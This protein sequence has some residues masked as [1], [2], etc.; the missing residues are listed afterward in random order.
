MCKKIYLS[1]VFSIAITSL[2][3]QSLIE[4]PYSRFGIGDL[5]SNTSIRASGMGGT[6]IA[7]PS[8]GYINYYNPANIAYVDSLSFIFDFGLNAT[9]KR[10]SIENPETNITRSDIQI[11]HLL[12]GFRITN[13]WSAAFGAMP[14]SNVEYDIATYDSLKFDVNKYHRFAGNGG[15]NRIFLA[16]AITP[17]ENLNIGIKAAYLFGN[18]YRNSGINFDDDSGAYINTLQRNSVSISDFMLDFGVQYSFNISENNV[19]YLGATYNHNCKLSGTKSTMIFNSLSTGGSAIID[20]IYN[21]PDMTG[22]I[23]IPQKIGFGIG[24]KFS[25]KLLLGVDYSTQKWSEAD[26]FGKKDSLNN[27]N[28]FS[29]GLE[30]LPI[31]ETGFAYRYSQSILYRIGAYY[32]NTYLNVNPDDNSIN[33]F[34]ISFGL[35][36]PVRRS[37]TSINLAMQ[38]GQRGTLRN[39]LVKENYITFA[40]SFNLIERWFERRRFE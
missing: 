33:D 23:T 14:F 1:L 17:I 26:F 36:L 39:D 31:G 8:S 10:Y 34:G 4:S 24:V 15:F 20:T 35:G 22:T 3:S 40:V 9:A 18:I 21:A 12:F 13:W 32:G 5:A 19:L 6:N 29:I 25:D 28:N 7:L 38:V 11:S 27:S 37:N 16:N 2:F 30:Y